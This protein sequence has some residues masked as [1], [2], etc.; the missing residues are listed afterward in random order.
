MGAENS[1]KNDNIKVTVEIKDIPNGNSQKYE[2]YDR[3]NYRIK[4]LKN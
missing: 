1:N 2:K 4:K 3:G